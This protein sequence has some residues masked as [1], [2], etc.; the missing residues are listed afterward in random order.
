MAS[1]PGRPRSITGSRAAET[2]TAAAGPVLR[3]SAV[4]WS[5]PKR[6]VCDGG[7]GGLGDFVRSVVRSFLLTCSFA[8]VMLK[9]RAAQPAMSVL[10]FKLYH[11]VFV[12]LV[13]CRDFKLIRQNLL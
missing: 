2:A 10:Q 8:Q 3:G 1:S 5:E 9:G 13:R 4:A 11:E 12:G 6:T 7:G